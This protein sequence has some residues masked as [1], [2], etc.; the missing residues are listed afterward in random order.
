MLLLFTCSN[1]LNLTFHIFHGWGHSHLVWIF[2]FL[3]LSLLIYPYIHR[4]IIISATLI[5]KMSEFLTN[6]HPALYNIVDLTIANRT[7]LFSH[8]TPYASLHF[9]HLVPI[10]CMTSPISIFSGLLSQGTWSY[11]YFLDYWTKVLEATS[12][13]SN[14]RIN[15]DFH[16]R[17]MWCITKLALHVVL[18]HLKPLDCSVCFQTSG[19][20]FTSPHVSS[21]STMSSAH[22]IHHVTSLSICHVNLSIA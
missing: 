21:T 9:I 7:C 10:D 13:R 4:S 20:L 6:Q 17:L 12:I 11:F 14:H 15:R 22:N 19:L 1:H 3:V 8:K 5:F 16:T 2:S 18:L